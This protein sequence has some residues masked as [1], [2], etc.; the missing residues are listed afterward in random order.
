MDTMK[1]IYDAK[2]TKFHKKRIDCKCE[3]EFS[4]MSTEYIAYFDI[5]F[6]EQLEV[7]IFHLVVFYCSEL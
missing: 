4:H 1:I 6:F 5:V 7:V 3:D 2:K